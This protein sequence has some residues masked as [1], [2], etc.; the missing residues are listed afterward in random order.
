MRD[1]RSVAGEAEQLPHRSLRAGSTPKRPLVDA[2][3]ARHQCR[4]RHARIDERLE[5]ILERE[6]ADALRTDLTDA[7]GSRRQTRRL[8]VD[9]DEVGLLEG[10]GGTGRIGEPDRLATPGEARLRGDDL[11][12]QRACDRS[13]GV[14]QR[15][16]VACRILR[17]DRPAARLDELDQPIR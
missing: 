1:D 8:E 16:Q 15:E 10:R 12:E 4:D 14:C 2:R 9:H 3:E 6:R 5:V 7:C 17:R 11:V 13:R